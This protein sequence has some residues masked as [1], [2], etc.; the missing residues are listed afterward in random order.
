M[1][2]MREYRPTD[3]GPTVQVHVTGNVDALAWSMASS[4]TVHLRP[5][6][7]LPLPTPTVVTVEQMTKELKEAGI[8]VSA[9]A[10]M[11]GVERKTIYNWIDGAGES[12]PQKTARLQAI[13]GLLFP[14]GFRDLRDIY[15]LWSTPV[16]GVTLKMLLSSGELDETTIGNVLRELTP[17]ARRSADRRAKLSPP[18][19]PNGFIE[20][21]ETSASI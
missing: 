21:L 11:A 7:P 14:A 17:E 3:T 19:M 12:R 6:R 15:R 18:D 2:I 9:I 20:G 8:P 4:P 16:G 13:H 5:S 10:D 1:T